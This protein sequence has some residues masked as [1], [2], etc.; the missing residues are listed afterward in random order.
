MNELQSILM[1]F[2]E[3]RRLLQLE[4]LLQE[5]KRNTEKILA[6]FDLAR[7]DSIVKAMKVK[8]DEAKDRIP[9]NPPPK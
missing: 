1:L 4:Q 7:E 8:T 2:A 9:P 5:I 6:Q 3:W